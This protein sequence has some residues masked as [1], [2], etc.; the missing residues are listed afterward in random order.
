V[1]VFDLER[2]LQRTQFT[3]R[4]ALDGRLLGSHTQN[5][6]GEGS[7]VRSLRDYEA[8]DDFRRI[9]HKAS[10]RAGTWQVREMHHEYEPDIW[11]VLDVSRSMR[12][13]AGPATKLSHALHLLLF[14]CL[15]AVGNMP[16]VGA[17]RL[18]SQQMEVQPLRQ[19]RQH[20]VRCL[21][22]LRESPA[23]DLGQTDLVGQLKE[24]SGVIKRP[25]VIFVV[26]DSVNPVIVPELVRM[27]LKHD[28]TYLL[29]RDA[30]DDLEL[31]FR[32]WLNL[33][34]HETGEQL[35][36]YIS[37]RLLRAE[38]ERIKHEK[39]EFERRLADEPVSYL[40]VQ[41]TDNPLAAFLNFA[42]NRRKERRWSA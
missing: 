29:V 9:D 42:R 20:M 32:S 23:P 18:G 34:D 14:S 38:R 16:R 41:T 17:I 1:E 5:R 39:A 13:S 28:V 11:L 21:E 36:G 3:L 2:Y 6:K 8:G 35:A 37:Q 7:E 19:S 26:S 30:V 22:W 12:V 10:A 40:R 25:A 31:P 33:R 15:W 27:S 4:R 24:L